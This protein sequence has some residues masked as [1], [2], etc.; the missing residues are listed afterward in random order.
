MLFKKRLHRIS[1]GLVLRKV[2]TDVKLILGF[3]DF[4]EKSQK[5]TKKIPK[6]SSHKIYAFSK[7]ECGQRLFYADPTLNGHNKKRTIFFRAIVR[8][9][10][11]FDHRVSRDSFEIYIMSGH[12]TLRS[13][14]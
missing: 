8:R 5:N 9:F 2:V 1:Y 11:R 4:G 13:N 14:R 6:F 10:F 12:L 7:N 3:W